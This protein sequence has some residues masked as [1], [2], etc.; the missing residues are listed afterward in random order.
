MKVNGRRNGLIFWIC[1]LHILWIHGQSDNPFHYVYYQTFGAGNQDA[2]VLGSPLPPGR[3]RFEY[4]NSWCPPKG[5][6]TIA[7]SVNPTEC[8]PEDWLF[9]SSD[10]T[11][12]YDH[13]MDN[14]YMML[15]NNVNNVTALYSDTIETDFCDGVTYHLEIALINLHKKTGC[16]PAFPQ[17]YVSLEPLVGHFVYMSFLTGDISY[18]DPKKI[19]FGRYGQDFMLPSGVKKVVLHINAYP[20]ATNN[21]DCASDFAI[22]DIIIKATGPEDRINFEGL[23][24]L[25]TVNSTCFQF[26]KKIKMEGHVSNYYSNPAYQ[27]EQSTDGGQKWFD[28]PG[29]NNI[30]YERIFSVPDTFLF[31]LRCAEKQNITSPSCG[32]T[33]NILKVDVDNIPTTH[34]VSSNSPVCAGQDLKLTADPGVSFLWHGPN[35]FYDNIRTP[36]IFNSSL[37]DSGWYYAD[38]F[39][40]GGCKVTDSSLI[41]MK[42]TDA[43]PAFS[44]KNNCVDV[45]VNFSNLTVNTSGAITS[46]LWDFGNGQSST[47]EKPKPAV[48]KKSGEYTIALNLSAPGCEAFPKTYSSK[49]TI[50]DPIE[51]S[52]Y[53]DI[54]VKEGQSARLL[55]R[56]LKGIAYEWIPS[57]DLDDNKINNPTYTATV[58]TQLKVLITDSNGCITTDLLDIMVIKKKDLYIPNLFTPNHD[59]I[60]DIFKP[61]PIESN[62]IQSLS[63]YS[64]NGGLIYFATGPEAAWDGTIKDG[65]A[66]SG[67]YVFIIRYLNKNNTLIH[68]KGDV[69]LIR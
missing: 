18:A 8:P 49:V 28:I 34:R 40:L 47:L 15:I 69:T 33:S 50:R 64:R 9:I 20:N 37:K 68:E 46:Y 32:V 59:G 38:I 29:A 65:P 41:A 3:T 13:T 22:D 24:D 11:S 21:T 57:S 55:A 51:G 2:S 16:V 30:N 19:E 58:S 45:P 25:Y 10:R 67:V 54:S 60:N 39:T 56:D 31:R 43:I 14:G 26:N 35:G 4:S 52:R 6:Y 7:R 48:Y 66:P 61:I 42:G 1:L 17:C 53:P 44:L 63:V 62:T 36:H 27:W 12:D 23:P 5:S